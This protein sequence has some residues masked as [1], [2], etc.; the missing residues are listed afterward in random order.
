MHIIMAT[1]EMSPYAKTGGLGDVLGS[2]PYALSKRG[3]E[4]SVFLPFYQCIQPPMEELVL[5]AK[6]PLG[7]REFA[8]SVVCISRQNGVTVYAIKK[9][10]FFE[11]EGIYGTAQR[12]YDDNPD[13]FIFFNKAII[14][15]IR[16]LNIR[17]I[18]HAHDWPTALLPV[19][20]KYFS[21]VGNFPVTRSVFTIH[22]LAYH[23]MFDAS[24]FALTN[25]PQRFF[26]VHGLEYHGRMNLMKG[27]ILFADKVTTVSRQYAKE[28]QTS[29][30][31]CGLEGV[32]Q[33]RKNDMTGIVNGID[34][35]IWNPETDK[36][37]KKNFNVDNL[38]GK[39]DC[40]KDLATQLKMEI[41]D[42][43][44]IFG[45]V[46]RFTPQKGLDLVLTVI[47]ELIKSG[48]QLAILGSGDSVYENAFRK[49]AASHPK[50]CGVVI[51]F[52]EKLAHQIFAG[53]DF[54]LMPSLEEPC[55]L[56]QLYAMRYA[57]IPIIHAVG[58]LE[59]TV[60][61][62]NSQTLSGTGLKF[63]TP[64]PTALLDTCKEG[65]E[66]FKNKA[67]LLTLRKNTM[68]VDCSWDKS[69][70]EYESLYKD[71]GA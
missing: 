24:L 47:P 14:E 37:I 17:G 36:H 9:E 59:D 20:I 46:S 64:K 39:A 22:N 40:K 30:Y 42:E 3:H 49:F 55:G 67:T 58:G 5:Q 19:F 71:L 48:A 68:K 29:H 32:L 43:K 11:R 34:Y 65:L 41:T 15:T 66:I 69:A 4:V 62:W 35:S 44:P 25:L 45:I 10:E 50:Q 7:G 54:F 16:A 13:R 60:E 6:L 26:S 31:G 38:K 57:S 61:Q 70:A 1:S 12:S 27:G 56:A 63:H 52:N 33:S 51:G 53:S 2:L 28:I 21:G 8:Y 23:G 18:V